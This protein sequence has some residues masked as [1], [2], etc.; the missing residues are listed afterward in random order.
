MEHFPFDLR[1]NINQ[2]T[3]YVLYDVT[4]LGNSIPEW[5]YSYRCTEITVVYN[6]D[7][8][9]PHVFRLFHFYI[10][11]LHY[12]SINRNFH[13]YLFY[14]AYASDYLL[15]TAIPKKGNI[16]LPKHFRGIQMLPAISVLFDRIISN[17]LEKWMW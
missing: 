8:H 13:E 14:I 11:T 10:S 7:A 9:A 3:L 4:F 17:R 16:S 6:P 2:S 5:F 1:Y 12:V 15:L